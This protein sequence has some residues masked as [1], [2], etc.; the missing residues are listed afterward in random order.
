MSDAQDGGSVLPATANQ[1]LGLNPNFGIFAGDLESG[2]VSSTMM[3]TETSALGSLYPKILFVRGNH[4]DQVSGSSAL[5]ENYFVAANRSLPAGVTNLTGLSASSLY[6]NYSFDYGNSRFIGLDVPGDADLL[7]T[8][9]LTFLDTRLTDAENIGLVHA[10]IFFHGPPYCAESTHC[11]C[12]AKNDAKCTPASFISVINKHP[13]VEATFGGHEHL[14]AWTHMDS[15]RVAGLTHPYEQFL[16]APSGT[17]T[18]NQYL[19]SNRVD[20][21]NLQNA[22][23]FGAVTVDGASFTV[24]FYRVGTT[25]PVWS[26]TFSQSGTPTNTPTPTATKTNT[27]VPPTATKTNTLVPPTATKTNTLVPPTATK[28]KTLVPPTATKTNTLVPP[29][30]TKTKTLVPPTATKTNTLVPP[31]RQRQKPWFRPLR[32]RQKPWFR[33]LRRRQK[34]WFRPLRRR[35]KPWFRPLRPEPTQ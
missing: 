2:G 7:T 29:T 28:T 22:M 21:A 23:A 27:L 24:N 11:S 26:K 19:Y 9:Q 5:W 17:G 10:F 32:Q 3:N 34:P 12:S 25:A 15:S 31:L 20:Y 18:Y 13:I 4:D 35:Q 30:A 1:A 6:L 8:A 14:L 33:P 16:T